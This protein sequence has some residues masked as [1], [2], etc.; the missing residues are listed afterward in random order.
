MQVHPPPTEASQTRLYQIVV[1]RLG[2]QTQINQIQGR[3]HLQTTTGFVTRLGPVTSD[4]N[5]AFRLLIRNDSN[6]TQT[7]SVQGRDSLSSLKFALV[8]TA[9]ETP[10][11]DENNLPADS[12]PTRHP[13]GSTF[14]FTNNPLFRRLLNKSQTSGHIQSAISETSRQQ[15]NVQWIL[16]ST[17]S[18]IPKS[19]LKF[20]E[21]K[22]RQLQ[23][24][25]IYQTEET[26]PS[27]EQAVL[28]F[29]IRPRKRPLRWQ[30]RQEIPFELTITPR[31]GSEGQEQKETAVLNVTSHLSRPVWVL[32]LGLLLLVCLLISGLATFRTSNTAR[33]FRATQEAA[34]ILGSTDIDGDGLPSDLEVGTYGTD[35]RNPDTDGDGLSDGL[36]VSLVNFDL[37]DIDNK[38]C[39][40]KVDC[41]GNGIS[42]PLEISFATPTPTPPGGFPFATAGPPPTATHI[43]TVTPTLL[44]PSPALP[45]ETVMIPY[46]GSDQALRLGDTADNQQQIITLT[47]NTTLKLP[48]NAAIQN[49][50]LLVVMTNPEEYGRLQQELGNLYVTEGT[51]PIN[52]QLNALVIGN[53][54]SLA[55]LK[56]MTL[57]NNTNNVL[58]TR[59][60]RISIDSDGTVQMRL[61]F[62]LGSNQDGSQDLLNIWSDYDK[63]TS[64]E[65]PPTLYL[66]YTV[67]DSSTP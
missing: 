20:P 50:N 16:R 65:H 1:R 47:F 54:D 42:D 34:V 62:E 61:F 38:I 15:R 11:F 53:T 44:P 24:S 35:P 55:N 26:V 2:K 21:V 40:I 6:K 57:A 13:N 10:I 22:P 25:E 67:P 4:T 19:S 43:P 3:V 64:L 60:E 48:I 27:G 14:S 7:Y 8:D 37:T 18:V 23:F 59:L 66:N 32:L 29:V 12:P 39:P 56:V 31:H 9:V 41:N 63:E 5:G 33:D 30:P 17:R 52:E 51:Q 58:V 36:E 46:T 28:F 49:G 45:T